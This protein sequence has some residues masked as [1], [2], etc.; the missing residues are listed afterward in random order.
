MLDNTIESP[1]LTNYQAN[2]GAKIRLFCF[3]HAGS[4]ASA[5][6]LWSDRL[7]PEI[8]V[9][10]IEY[11]GRGSRRAETAFV[12]IQA[13]VSALFPHLRPAL[14][15]PFAVFG[16]SM[17][18]LIAFEF[19]R[20]LQLRGGPRPI[21]LVAAACHAPSVP[22]RDPPIHALPEPDF[23]EELRSLNGTSS[24]I[25]ADPQLLRLFLPTLRAD[26]EA[27]ETYSYAVG[28]KL[29]CPITAYGGMTDSELLQEDIEPWRRETQGAF[30]LEMFPG[31]HFFLRTAE[32]LVLKRL[33]RDLATSG[34]LSSQAARQ[35]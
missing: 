24:N 12:R 2:P 34:G 8:E 5:F 17:G 15:K 29:K 19:L 3:P 4:S 28:P 14:T 13:L 27:A 22:L 18:A 9:W 7:A 25:L 16:H 35:T 20:R 10:A 11:P 6:G 21:T 33:S 26:L 32:T 30:V 31:D 23:V 1:W